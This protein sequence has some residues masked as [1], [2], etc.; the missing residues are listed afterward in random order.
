M[1]KRSRRGDVEN[2]IIGEQRQ[3][4][5]LADHFDARRRIGF[6]IDRR[7][8]S[9]ADF[10]LDIEEIDMLR[11]ELASEIVGYGNRCL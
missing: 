8:K 2:G 7:R 5:D 11:V 6:E 3:T 10:T 4:A 9:S 1:V